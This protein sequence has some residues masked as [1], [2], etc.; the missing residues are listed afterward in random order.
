MIP[1]S[2]PRGR[3]A[4][5]EVAWIAVQ[6]IAIV[7]FVYLALGGRGRNLHVPLRFGVDSLAY[8]LQTKTTLDTGWWWVNPRISA[9][10]EFHALLFPSN[11]TV[12]QLLVVLIRPFTRDLGLGINLVWFGMLALGGVVATYCLRVLGI[13]RPAALVL[14]TLAGVSPYAAYRNIEHFML[15]P[16]LVPFPVTLAILVAAGTIGIV[17]RR[18]RWALYGGCVL[19]GFNYVYYAF[20]ACVLLAASAVAALAGRRQ[21]RAAAAGVLGAVL[22]VA[23]TG[24][25]LL[26][27]LRAWQVEG[28]PVIIQE[29]APA[30]AE[31]YGLK[32]RHLLSPVWGHTF[33]PLAAWNR[34]DGWAHF[35]MEGENQTARLGLVASAGF[36]AAL[37]A[38]LAAARLHGTPRARQVL[39]AGQVTLAGVLLGTIGGFGALFNLF[40]AP[41][42]RAYNRVSPFL[43]FAALFIVAVAAE[44]VARRWRPAGAVLLAGILVVGLWDQRYPFF[45]LNEMAPPIRQEYL[46]LQALVWTM[47]QE[48]PAGARVVQLPFMLYLNDIGRQK[49]APYDELKPY[50][51]STHLR[52]SFPALSD[53][54]LRWEQAAMRIGDADL[55]GVMAREGFAAIWVDTYGYADGGRAVLAALAGVPGARVAWQTE[56]YAVVDIRRVAPAAQGLRVDEGPSTAGLPVCPSPARVGIGYVG[57]AI[58]PFTPSVTVR[59]GR[60]LRIVGWG[61]PESGSGVIDLDGVLDGVPFRGYHGFPRG[62]IA[63]ALGEAYRDS[64]FAVVVPGARLTPG[65]HRFSVRLAAAG[66]ACAGESA[67]LTLIVE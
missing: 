48:L 54:Q 41:D 39:A 7:L 60:D 42:I 61:M 46:R 6:A 40:V 49:M 28:K 18:H 14:G 67:P 59:R 9:P 35:P 2:A 32:I 44:R 47:E 55:P 37:L 51:A 62:D 10:S 5:T 31:I 19:V 13:G 12:D 23:A 22:I 25:N 57:G 34:R 66:A 21:P 33:A 11:S 8:L 29:K 63:T 30:E 43:A 52:W 26:P 50:L 64:G 27:S 20:F 24:V 3:A 36:L 16:Y 65:R 53:A 58:G 17:A 15:A 38:L 45:G 56:R 1:S 4:A